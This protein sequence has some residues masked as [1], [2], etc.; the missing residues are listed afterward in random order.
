MQLTRLW[1]EHLAAG[2][3]RE[4]SGLE[5][6]GTDARELDAEITACISALLTHTLK[7]DGRIERRLVEVSA[8]LARR[9]SSSEP[10]VAQY[11][12]RLNQLVSAVLTESKVAS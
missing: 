12:A 2:C 9:Q 11:C 7:V 5:I 8:D 4:L 6:A 10:P 3:P 1:R